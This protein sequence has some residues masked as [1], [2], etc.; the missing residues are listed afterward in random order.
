MSKTK[1]LIEEASQF[2]TICY[3]E[4][5]KEQ[6]IEERMKEIQ[7]EIEKTGTY[8]H[9][10]EEI[11]HGSRMAWRNSNR[12]I[13]RL[14]WS[15]MHILDAREVNDEEG[16]YNA[17][18]HHIKYATND[19]KV[20]PTITIFKQ[21]QGEENNIR[22]YNH[23]LIR[24]AGYKTEMGVIGDSHSAAFTDFCQELGWK[25]EGTNYDVLP[26]VFSVDGKEPVYKE[27]PKKEVKEVPIEHP[28]YPISSLG[29]KWYGVP[30]ISDMRLEIGGISYT[31]APFN[32][33][34]MG[35]EIGARNL[36]DHDRYN[37]LPAV[38]EMMNLDTSRNGTLW[39]DKALIE[40]N[41]AVLHSFKKQGVSIV[42]HHTAAQQFQQFEKQEA[43]CG[44]V[45]T[46]NW[47]WLIPPLSP[48]TTHIYHKPY[49]NEILKPNFFHK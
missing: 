34:Y 39:K 33:W 23:Q 12:C 16:V 45:V 14:F 17:L 13:G 43:A 15:K 9:T 48:A 46:G 42:D 25:G 21:Y 4:L 40:L 37:L 31:A 49:P 32:G 35:T 10:F 26:L 28:E 11:V 8:E 22:I 24:Y 41:I 29:V 47:V 36:A 5:N 44:R 38:A 19:G 1:Q 3:K 30:M 7:V 6:F 27:I 20:K 18:I 2:I